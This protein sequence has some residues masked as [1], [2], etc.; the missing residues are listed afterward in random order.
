VT[1]VPLLSRLHALWHWNRLE[2]ELQEEIQFHLS[3]AAEERAASGIDRS[4][5]DV[6]AHKEFGSTARVLE[7]VREAWRPRLLG[8]L[9]QDVRYGWRSMRRH[10]GFSLVAV[11]T[12]GVGIGAAAV[13]VSVVETVLLE[14]LPYP[15]S[16]RLVRIVE[17]FPTVSGIR[18]RGLTYDEFLAWRSST[19]TIEN[20]MAISAMAQRTVRT[21]AGTV[22][23]WGAM[24]SGNAFSV[25]AVQAL[26]GRT[27]EPQDDQHPDVV[28]LSYETWRR[29]FDADR[30]IVGRVIELRGGA[31]QSATTPRLLT[32]VGVLPSDFAFER[33]EFFTPLVVRP[34]QRSP[35][36]TTIGRLRNGVSLSAALIEANA[37]GTELRPPWPSDAAPLSGPRFS[38]E[39]LKERAVAES[40]PA[41][42]LFAAAVAVLLLIACANLATLLL[43]RS[44]SRRAE[45]AT[46]LALGASRARI[47][48][49]ILTECLLLAA[50]GGI[51]AAAFAAAGLSLVTSLATV[52][53]PGI[54]RLMFGSTILPRAEEIHVSVRLIGIVFALAALTGLAVGLLPALQLSRV[55][56]LS[57]AAAR[58]GSHGRRETVARRELVVLQMVLATVLLVGAGLLFRS[59]RG[60]SAIDKGYDST[61][62]VAMNLLLPD[63]YPV[64]RKADTIDAVLRTLRALPQVRAAGFS[65]HGLLIGEEI[66]PGL[67]LPAGK[68]ESEME[69]AHIRVRPVS[70][71]FLTA[72]S[73]PIVHG[74]DFGTGDELSPEPTIVMNQLAA[75]LCFGS[76]PPIDQLLSWK[77]GQHSTAVRVIGV[78]DNLRQS[79]LTDDPYPEIFIDYR[80]VL[81]L[82]TAWGETA[83]REN[84]TA[85]GFLSFAALVHGDPAAALAPIRRAV[86]DVDPN[87]GIDALVPMSQLVDDSLTRPRFHAVVLGIFA[88]VAAFLA[89]I[90]VFGVMSYAAAERRREFG[91]RMALGATPAAMLGAVFTQGLVVSSGGIVVGLLVATVAAPLL[92][93]LLFGIQPLDPLTFGVTSTLFLSV[94]AVA[95]F[96]PAWRA[97]RVCPAAALRNDT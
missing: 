63:G 39:S 30:Q 46:R 44:S 27:L 83:A 93:S 51:V 4:E 59:L 43:A 79:T 1:R 53:A 22:G 58:G 20:T 17:R 56:R 47:V 34:G 28:L 78:V 92:G 61:N 76:A 6:A 5:A 41:L 52:D 42:R 54:F 86:R 45:I 84:E 33:Y 2:A 35:Q 94:S 72:M 70:S 49:Q 69:Q 19:R 60:L 65:R 40:R 89:A 48:R 68:T 24:A 74:R 14:P 64:P 23:L 8:A 62:V 91:I 32:V 97:T 13:I 11:L 37:F 9:I 18:E 87:L 31:L 3:E 88:A 29:H 55:I 21:S 10:R 90:G 26:I 57:D 71:G 82:F 85:I 81:A 73:V 66:I 12:L 77:L 67:F 80:Q 15:D 38:V 95:C 75:R 96:I 36:V 25:L 7:S 50:V 16:D